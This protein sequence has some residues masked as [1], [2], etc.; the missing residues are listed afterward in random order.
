MAIKFGC[1]RDLQK[2]KNHDSMGGWG[3]G[4]ISGPSVGHKV[5]TVQRGGGTRSSESY[6]LSTLTNITLTM[7]LLNDHLESV[8]T[9][10]NLSS[11]SP[12]FKAGG[13]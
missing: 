3:G 6:F 7:S 13:Y 11:H 2:M 12:F 10:P 8:Q 5:R 4:S 9:T 1:Q